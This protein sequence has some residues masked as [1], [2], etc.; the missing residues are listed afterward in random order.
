[1][2]GYDP[3]TLTTTTELAA[4]AAF[5]YG[6][7]D[8]VPRLTPVTP[9]LLDGAPAFTLTY[10]RSDAA[11][12]ISTA[13]RTALVFFDSRLAYVGWNPL[14]VA[15]EV[16]VLQDPE[17]ELFRD[18]LLTQELLKY[19]P[20]RQIIDSPLL[21]RENW[22]YLPRWVVRVVEAGGPR[23]VA[24]RAAP[25]HGV[26]AY[27]SGG[28]LAADTVQVAGLGTDRV[29]V[30]PLS[31]HTPPPV[32]SPAALLLHDFATPDM[33]PRTTFLATGRLENGRLLVNR[34]SG[35]PELGKRPGII[36]RWRG[37]RDL[38]RRCKA[39]LKEYA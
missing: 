23:P 25:D 18:A 30:R 33:D 21:Q 8:G 26:L 20:G 15:V 32:E 4:V 28:D 16:E 27:E 3:Q 35:S 13:A 7:P 36:A 10:A 11:R 31:G 39:G 6:G 22:W 17:G 12:E 1:M 2:D 24:R 19:P 29:S 14:A 9:L 38:E 5:A 37:Q 34:R